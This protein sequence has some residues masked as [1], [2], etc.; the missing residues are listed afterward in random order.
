MR[1]FLSCLILMVFISPAYAD[2][3]DAAYYNATAKGIAMVVIKDG[4]VVFENYINGGNSKKTVELAS[5]TKSFSSVIAAAAVQ[6]GFLSLDEK[7]AKTLHEW[8]SDPQKSQITIRQILSLTSGID[9]PRPGKYP[10][11]ADSIK[12][13]LDT[14]PGQAFEYGPANFQIFGEIMQRKL[15]SYKGGKY[16][17]P[18]AYLQQRV[19][20]HIGVKPKNWDI[21]K[22]DDLPILS[23][24]ADVSAPHWAKFGQFILQG[25][26]W[27]GKQ[28]VDRKALK[29]SVKGSKANAAYG[30]TWWINQKPDPRAL[31]QSKIMRRSTD[32]FSHPEAKKLPNDLFMAAGY[33]DQRLYIIPSKNMV[34]VRQTEGFKHKFLKKWKNRDLI[35]IKQTENFSD[36]TFLLKTL[37]M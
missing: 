10:A 25:G 13:P 12:L 19:L 31:A 20:N 1:V 26:S 35:E 23:M 16:K 28:L 34:I 30:L 21:G 2:Y 17:N 27:S 11:Y 29:E 33:G 32:L 37:D 4:K 7:A 22:K 36:V 18:A 9:T 8:R 15:K 3:K 24:G 5:G 6:D 14:K